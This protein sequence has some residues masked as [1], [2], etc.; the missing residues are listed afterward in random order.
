MAMLPS[1]RREVMDAPRAADPFLGRG[2]ALLAFALPLVLLPAASDFYTVP[3]IFLLH[4]AILLGLLRVAGRASE[5]RASIAPTPLSLPLLILLGVCLLS[6]L[7]AAFPW[8]GVEATWRLWNGIL[9]YHLA[10]LALTPASARRWFVGAV[11]LSIL[12]VAIYG[13]LQ[14][15][16]LN[17]LRLAMW[18]VPVSSLGN[19]G[20]VAEYLVAALP[21]ALA[22]AA[23][24]DNGRWWLFSPAVLLGA[25]HLLLTQ[26]RAGWLGAALGGGILLLAP[27]SPL[28]S[29]VARARLRRLALSGLLL[30]VGTGL[31]IPDL[32]PASLARL[33]SIVDPDQA[34]ARV[35][36]LI[37]RG[38]LDLAA[39]HPILG[40]GLGNFEFAYPEVRSVEE[41]HLSR[42]DVVDDAHNEYLHAMAETGLLG[43]AV[44]L[45]FLFRAA[46][47]ARD[48]LRS[49]ETREE[50]LPLIAG[51]AGLLLYAG[52]GFPFKDP[53]SGAYWWM[54]LGYLSALGCRE[55]A[56]AA[57]TVPLALTRFAAIAHSALAVL[58]VFGTFLADL[59]VRRMQVFSRQGR[60]REA[61]AEYRAAL[62]LYFP[63]AW[64]HRLR[65]L[66]HDD[67][68]M[69]PLLVADHER[70]LRSR[71]N[72]AW[73][74][75]ELGG[76]YGMLGRFADAKVVLRQAL[77]LRPD[78]S[79]AHENLGTAL[80][81]TGD[82]Q[83]ALGELD[84]ATRLDPLNARP[85]YKLAV[86]L[87]RAG[88]KDHAEE[89]FRRARALDPALPGFLQGVHDE[90]AF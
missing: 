39:R 18:Q 81:L 69:V 55:D 88:R 4:V 2:I 65:S 8:A 36:L 73:L 59:H 49:P 23:K 50:A 64:T 27:S 87:Y 5:N 33:R 1:A 57:R 47:S 68:R 29:D 63:L 71:S 9:L 12:P 83:G 38:A 85:R 75:A 70:R 28:R 86:A 77:A 79:F 82:I 20:F 22:L 90:K 14:A 11:G 80:L 44:F 48:L 35:R 7:G 66:V 17:F 67:R 56:A 52:F 62:R 46:R 84:L 3:K 6:L 51:L 60:D 31:L 13:I 43:L 34:T 72:D 26:S 10:V 30:A 45:W 40:V 25:I 76:L 41:W 89:Q 24:K 32:G 37:W 19:T 21:L 15:M 16:G 58:L 42:R 74:L 54:F 78:L 53:T 61:E